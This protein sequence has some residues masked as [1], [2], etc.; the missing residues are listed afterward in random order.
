MQ[1]GV[2]PYARHGLDAVG[3]S[4]YRMN[5]SSTSSR[6]AGCVASGQAATE[7]RLGTPGI[8]QQLDKKLDVACCCCCH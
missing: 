2:P 3:S 7:R 4:W 8:G 5:K 1:Q 6:P